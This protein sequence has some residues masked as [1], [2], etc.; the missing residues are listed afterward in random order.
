[1]ATPSKS[2]ELAFNGRLR[3]NVDGASIGPN[4]FQ[5]LKNLRYT[6]TNVRGVQGH[7]KINTTVLADTAIRN[8]IHFRKDQPAESHVV[9]EAGGYC[10]DNTTAVPGT[11]DFGAALNTVAGASTGRFAVAPTGMLARCTGNE[12]L[13]WGGTEYRAAALIDYPTTNQIYDYG[14][15]INSTL[16]DADHSATIHG[17]VVST[18]DANT[19]LLLH[20]NNNVTD[21][22]SRH[23]PSDHS[24]GYLVYP[25][26]FGTHAIDFDGINNYV[27]IPDSADFNYAGS[28][29]F[30]IDF[31]VR[32]LGTVRGTLYYQETDAT[33]YFVIYTLNGYIYV[34]VV[35]GG[36][37]TVEMVS[38][39]T[40]TYWDYTHVAVVENGDSWYLFINGALSASI[41]D[42]SRC[43]DYSGDVFIGRDGATGSYAF[44][45]NID[46]FRVSNTYRYTSNFSP[47]VQEYGAAY[48][49]TTYIGSTLPIKGF[50]PY[51]GTAN[52][53]TST[54]S[55]QYWG[56]GGWTAVSSLSDGT[57]SGGISLAQTGWVTFTSTVGLSKLREIEK[58]IAH[59][60]KVV[61]SGAAAAFTAVLPNVTVDVPMQ[62]IQ[63]IWDGADRPVGAFLKN[64]TSVFSDY[65]VNVLRN[66]I[67]STITSTYADLS[68]ITSSDYLIVGFLERSMGFNVN[69]ASDKPNTTAS[70]M[71]VD[72]WNGTAWTPLTINDGTIDGTKSFAKSGFVTWTSPVMNAEFR[73]TGFASRTTITTGGD[74][75]G[76]F[77]AQWD[78]GGE[79]Q[80]PIVTN[81]TDSLLKKDFPLYY[82]RIM[83]NAGLSANMWVY[84]VSGIP[85]PADV[86]G[87]VFPMEHA[88]R[89]LLCNNEDGWANNVKY[90]SFRTANVFNGEDAGDLYFGGDEAVVAGASIYNRFGSTV[91]NLAVLCKKGET[92][93]LQGD[94]PDTW[95][96]FQ[97]SDKI[98]CVAPQS[99]V[100]V[101]VPQKEVSAGTS[102]NSAIWV[103]S[104]G[105]EMFNGASITLLS[106]DIDDLF[107]SSRSTY[108][109]A[110][111]IATITA[112]YDAKRS[113]YH[114]VV[115]GS[116]EYVFDFHR[117]KWFQ[118]V[119]G[120]E[121]YG[122]FQV[123][124]TNGYQYCYG[125]GN[126]GFV[127]R[128]ENGTDFNGTDIAH[129]L[130]T[131]DFALPD[132]SIMEYSQIKWFTL[133]A[134]AKTVTDQNVAMAYYNDTGT[135][136]YGSTTISPLRSGY[137][138]INTIVHNKDIQTTFH[139]FQFSISTDD[140]TTGFEPLYLGIRYTVFPRE[141]S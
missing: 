128:I 37:T 78:S 98:G 139:G 33:N 45:G 18:V 86:R 5:V 117:G 136:V 20:F 114:M 92:W 89:L 32:R 58:S 125:Y 88:G 77:R 52:T 127:F 96:Q 73:Q 113:E 120:T 57:A 118:I 59:W 83:F 55:V 62:P 31:W 138:L 9:V 68:S 111:A 16:S 134:K 116:Y 56:T 121:L 14:D 41:T 72:Y 65:S 141:I 8:G 132:G 129:T 87:Y 82:Y 53:Q 94:N 105:V 107:D 64:K 47:P 110:A 60:Y 49:S 46:E 112:F 124:D 67:D 63:D 99:M 27:H 23:T 109:T 133:V 101:N 51:V 71:S 93:V 140:E 26:K 36:T 22:A 104:R 11:G 122:G 19:M 15:I 43:A 13:L 123:A 54:M 91:T 80:T 137:R 74:P 29:V 38:S 103:S 40:T 39:T 84:Y 4:D 131:G 61:V 135:S 10:Y 44:Y 6:D 85:T 42:T 66:E 2:K 69:I 7:T 24:N 3:T 70:Q 108:L 35:A 1:M 21:S 81:T 34:K 126:A 115:P 17:S 75:P 50:K 76:T 90:T 28:G 48:S 95:K 106:G 130:R 25:I 100:A 102:T 12:S 30:T 97:I 79:T 119:R